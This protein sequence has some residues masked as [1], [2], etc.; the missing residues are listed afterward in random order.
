[1]WRLSQSSSPRKCRFHL[2]F[3]LVS[4]GSCADGVLQLQFEKLTHYKVGC[5]RLR[6]EPIVWQVGTR[7][8]L[9]NHHCECRSR[10]RWISASADIGLLIL[11]KPDLAFPVVPQ[12]FPSA[13]VI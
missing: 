2:G 8:T 9:F 6:P 3:G 1:M 4:D 5:N 10:S 13:R 12:A 7:G 11:L